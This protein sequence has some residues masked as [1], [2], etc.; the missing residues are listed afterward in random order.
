[1]LCE[2]HECR[3]QVAGGMSLCFQ[4]FKVGGGGGSGGGGSGLYKVY[5]RHAL[6][7]SIV[8]NYSV[9]KVTQIKMVLF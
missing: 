7:Y 6:K 9:I 8:N 3:S 1:M 2:N 4:N 5:G